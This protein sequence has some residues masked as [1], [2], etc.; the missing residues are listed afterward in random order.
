MTRRMWCLSATALIASAVAY[1]A[2]LPNRT[3]RPE[4]AAR[5]TLVSDERGL[6]TSGS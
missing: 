4:L 1:A 2:V 3:A 5:E 6:T